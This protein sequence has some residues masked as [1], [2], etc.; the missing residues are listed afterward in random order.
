MIS[1][2]KLVIK[3]YR[4]LQDEVITL[5][6]H[7]T[8]VVGSNN[9]GKTS[10]VE[11]LSNTFRERKDYINID[12]L[13][14][15]TRLENDEK[16]EGIINDN[17]LSIDDKK[18]KLHKIHKE[19]KKIKIGVA[20]KYDDESDDLE[21]FS[22][23]LSDIDINKKNFYFLIE[24]EYTPAKEKD[25][26]DILNGERDFREIFSELQSNI[27]YCN[28]DFKNKI[29]IPDK[30]NFYD[31]F[32]YHCVY[33]IRRLADTSDDKQNFLSKHLLK[34]VQN[35]SVWK[36]SLKVLI[37][38]INTL[39]NQQKL[40]NEIDA[41]TLKHIKKT[42]HSFS[43]TNGGNTGNLGIDFRLE[44]KD[45][46]KV[47]LD[48]IHIY[49][50]QDEGLKVKEQKQGLGYSNLI[51]L[52]LEAQIFS[53]KIDP[54][55]VNLLIFEEPEAHLH[56]QMENIFIRYINII[57]NGSEI[58]VEEV[59]GDV[60]EGEVQK[61]AA[62]T[63]IIGGVEVSEEESKA[64][65]KAEVATAAAES[66]S[67][68]TAIVLVEDIVANE[69]KSV[70]FQML[71]TSHSS[72]MTKTIGLN[73]IRVFR[74]KGHTESKVY[75]LNHFINIPTINK[76]FY[77]KFFQFNMV[78][79]VFAD[80][81]ILFEGD[82]E[83]L[84]FKYLISNIKDFEDLSTQYISYIQVGGAYAY[85]YLDLIQYLEIKTLIFTDIDYEYS[86]E[87]INLETDVLTKDIIN[88]STT[89]DTI[90]K[91]TGESIIANIFKKNTEK[92]GMFLEDT[93][94]CLK[95]Q[96]DLDGYART[97]EDAILNKLLNFK[98]VFDKISKADFQLLIDNNKL[99]LPNTSKS[100]TSL[101]DRI[102]KLKNKTD[103]M[104]SLIETESIEEAIP[105]Y[106]EE[107]LNW[108]KD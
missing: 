107:G 17:N 73:N 89:N 27:Y 18:D 44:N 60:E 72:E 54:R 34:T 103:F 76:E 10:L 32:N 8:A 45:I 66:L 4:K 52:L 50:E 49:F 100:E 75:D 35:N 14:S 97:L 61:A 101:R 39:L 42:L 23:Y 59:E 108:L 3:N 6:N 96:T 5:D 92:S 79:M 98:T 91:F 58:K 11:L 105:N 26:L 87:D 102:D 46:E 64:K 37:N 16:I 57:A 78:E 25:I 19:L 74:S 85:Q 2:E 106:I 65:S 9:S 83:R 67:T 62:T 33:A 22:R 38:S 1:I 56:P 28:E 77:Q 43:K 31:L 68:S 12:D 88:R 80:K 13:N 86:K 21:Y 81:L 48:F 90:K 15:K 69:E 82:A 7:L 70:P 40:S 29:S 47:L 94:V 51:Y 30:S 104:Y 41:I 71:I 95:F 84:L 20:T 53:E 36:E 99:L 93:S 55:K 24:Y 63:E